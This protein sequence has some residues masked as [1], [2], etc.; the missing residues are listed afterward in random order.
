MSD[1]NDNNQQGRSKIFGSMKSPEL[2][3][4]MKLLKTEEASISIHALSREVAFSEEILLKMIQRLEESELISRTDNG[5]MVAAPIGED[6]LKLAIAAVRYGATV[7]DSA[8][9]LSWKEFESFCLKVLE[10]NEYSCYQGFWFKSPKG[11]RY[12]CDV[13]ATM[14]SLILVADCKHYAGRVKGLN[15]AVDKHLER[16]GAFAKSVPTLVRKI[17][18]ILEWDQATIT[19]IMVTLFPENITVIEGVP[20]VP[21]FK[22]NQFLQEITSNIDNITHIAVKPSKQKRLTLETGTTRSRHGGQRGKGLKFSE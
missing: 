22:L 20:I 3:V 13:V 9:A 16:V 17:P 1:L 8:S 12:E 21:V 11:R 10:G 14:N 18:Q 7:E 2:S 5:M 15:A 6:R 19:P 4:I